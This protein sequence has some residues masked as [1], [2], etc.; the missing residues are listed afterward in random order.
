MASSTHLMLLFDFS[1]LL[2]DDIFDWAVH[3]ERVHC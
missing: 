1:E 2:K 3:L